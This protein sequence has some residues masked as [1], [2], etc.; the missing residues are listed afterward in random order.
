MPKTRLQLI[1]SV[2][3]LVGEN[4]LLDSS[5]NLGQLVADT[6]NTAIVN[7]AGE[8]RANVFEQVLAQNV[9]SPDYLVS[10]L[11]LPANTLQVYSVLLR[12]STGLSSGDKLIPLEYLPLESIPIE[13]SY[14][15]VG[16]ELFVSPMIAR[17]FTLRVHV[18]AS[19]SL[20]SSDSA[21]S[22]LPDVVIPVVQHAAAAILALSYL[23]DS[24][25]AAVHR[26]I[27]E[28]LSEKLRKQYG[29]NRAKTFNIGGSG[30]AA[31]FGFGG[32]SSVAGGL[33][34]AP[35]ESPALTGTPTINGQTIATDAEL[36]AAITPYLTSA[37]AASTY[38]TQAN[39]AATYALIPSTPPTN[40]NSTSIATTEYVKNNLVN[41][42]TTTAAT[43]T[44]APRDGANLTNA[45]ATTPPWGDLDTSLATTQFV[46]QAF[47]PKLIVSKSSSQSVLNNVLTTLTSYGTPSI[48]SDN[49]FNATAGLANIPVSRGG[50]YII[51]GFVEALVSASTV[52]LGQLSL[53]VNV[54]G[55]GST[56]VDSR[57]VNNVS[58]LTFYCS[59]SITLNL[60]AGQQ[61]SLVVLIIHSGTSP[62]HSV[63]SARLTLQ[64]IP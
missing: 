46:S 49:I 1:N 12:I 26:N 42:L 48:D 53:F 62:V 54:S 28:Q 7:I 11:T 40:D 29:S 64:R 27:A 35:I 18:I 37:S 52:G 59:G 38:L 58:F 44:Y 56:I 16:S 45:T 33:A 17:P 25:Q 51:S 34:Y 24:N 43:T 57:A 31:S 61:V 21:D 23:D 60:V 22:G 3:Q 10:A 13:P 55:V 36:A 32:V 39:A 9:T 4:Q 2:L 5:G 50:T 30:R 63:S 19:T 41:Y 15:V 20:P 6:I 47:T 8:T 14:S